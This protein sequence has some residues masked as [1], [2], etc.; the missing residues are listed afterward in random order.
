VF[1]IASALGPLILVSAVALA[2]WF[3]LNG[4]FTIA[5]GLALAL[6][7]YGYLVLWGDQTIEDRLIPPPP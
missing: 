2:G 5:A 1:D 3:A 4:L 7:C 6:A